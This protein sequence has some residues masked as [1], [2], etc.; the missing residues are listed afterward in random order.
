MRT[1][2][3]CFDYNKLLGTPYVSEKDDW[4]HRLST[5]E[6]TLRTHID[7]IPEKEVTIVNLFYNEV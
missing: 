5:L 3:D 2:E 6:N 1:K 7:N 4:N